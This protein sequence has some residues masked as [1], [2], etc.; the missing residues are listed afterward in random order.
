METNID[1]L[2]KEICKEYG[3]P[4]SE[5]APSIKMYIYFKT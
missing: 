1:V 5:G 2:I 3:L 4:E